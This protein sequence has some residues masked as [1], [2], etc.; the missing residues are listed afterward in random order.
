MKNPQF[1]SL[2]WGSLTLA[3]IMLKS[4]CMHAMTSKV[5]GC[6]FHPVLEGFRP[7]GY[8]NFMLEEIGH[9]MRLRAKE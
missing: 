6:Q 7:F 8:Y 4:Q 3:P 1:N 5:S 9:H 2:V